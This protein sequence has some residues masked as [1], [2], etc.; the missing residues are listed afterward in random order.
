MRDEERK[1]MQHLGSGSE[2]WMN[3]SVLGAQQRLNGPTNSPTLWNRGQQ[4]EFWELVQAIKDIT[5]EAARIADTNDYVKQMG[6]P[7]RPAPAY[8]NSLMAVR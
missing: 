8:D 6:A 4:P 2:L 7:G 5:A 1:S 3:A